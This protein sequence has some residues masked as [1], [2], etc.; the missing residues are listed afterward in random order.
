M[1]QPQILQN[2]QK[3]CDLEHEKEKK[4]KELSA[5]DQARAQELLV[6][7]SISIDCEVAYYSSKKNQCYDN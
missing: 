2:S 3:S 5:K 7:L 6:S 4:V 1:Q